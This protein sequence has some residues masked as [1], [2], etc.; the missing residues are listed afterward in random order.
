[1]PSWCDYDRI[2]L[3]IGIVLRMIQCVNFQLPGVN[4]PLAEL[5]AVQCEQ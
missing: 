1:M 2:A 5:N 4:S 3:V